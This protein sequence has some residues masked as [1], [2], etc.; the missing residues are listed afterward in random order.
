M[1]A[2]IYTV[3]GLTIQT[4][5]PCPILPLAPADALPGILVS[6]GEVPRHL[7]EPVTTRNNWEIEPGRYLLRGGKRSGRFLAEGGE[8]V[9]VERN[10]AAENTMLAFHLLGAILAALLRQRGMLVLH[11]NAA[12]TPL[13]DL[14]GFCTMSSN[15][16]VDSGNLAGL[17]AVMLSGVSGSGKSTTLAAL[18]AR[19]CTMLTDD[20][21]VLNFDP[22]GNVIALPGI[23]QL[24]LTE[25]AAEGLGQDISDLPR[26]PW[27]RMKA[28][29]STAHAMAAAPAP[30]RSIYLLDF[31]DD[32][33]IQLQ[34]L[35]GGE[36][37]A[38][39]QE[40]VYG[41]MLPSE[42]PDLFPLFSAVVEQ[43][44]LYRLIRPV[45]QWTVEEVADLILTTDHCTPI[46]AH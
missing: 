43:T 30:L 11:G 5:F 4:P 37:F 9:T 25:D 41:P 38:A 23:P 7:A 33:K 44:S 35:T 27:K 39:L 20:I 28:P 31:H 13:R 45:H 3:Y 40:C 14:P 6:Y 19:G 34:P 10:P 26:Y 29:V 36:K 17:G 46:T 12:L 42:H 16:S 1:T 21:T 22:A 24:H 8:R 15:N 18:L 2:Y 32:D